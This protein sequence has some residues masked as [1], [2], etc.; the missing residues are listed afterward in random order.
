[1]LRKNPSGLSGIET[2]IETGG[3]NYV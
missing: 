3:S 1:M 2:G